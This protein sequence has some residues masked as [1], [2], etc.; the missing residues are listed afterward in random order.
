[1][2][3]RDSPYRYRDEVEQSAEHDPEEREVVIYDG[4]AM[5]YRS[6]RR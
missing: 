6:Y 3:D 5:S 4:Q 2:D 1:M